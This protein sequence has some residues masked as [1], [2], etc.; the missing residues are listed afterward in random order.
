MM[1]NLQIRLLVTSDIHGYVYPTTF[2]DTS[3]ENMGLAKLATIIHRERKRDLS[4]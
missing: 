4:L 2:R 3:P 1:K